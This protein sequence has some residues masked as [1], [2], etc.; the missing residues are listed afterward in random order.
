MILNIF[1]RTFEPDLFKLDPVRCSLCEL[2]VLMLE[3][4]CRVIGL[5]AENDKVALYYLLCHLKK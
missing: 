1:R 2:S 3:D 5:E 4:V